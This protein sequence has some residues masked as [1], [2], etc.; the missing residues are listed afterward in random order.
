MGCRGR[1]GRC[2]SM[3]RR[4]SSAGRPAR[5]QGLISIEGLYGQ[6]CHA[7]SPLLT[8]Q[9]CTVPG[10]YLQACLW[11]HTVV[12]VVE[13]CLVSTVASHSERPAPPGTH[14]G[15]EQLASAC[16]LA[17]T[18]ARH[19][20]HRGVKAEHQDRDAQAA[21]GSKAAASAAAHCSGRRH[22]EV[23]CAQHVSCGEVG[24]RRGARAAGRQGAG[25][26]EGQGDAGL[27]LHLQSA[28]RE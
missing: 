18:E 4:R 8:A 17:P 24:S 26:R 15:C 14:C 11:V 12:S 16:Q 23:P 3:D 7:A 5:I 9:T 25:V 13:L 28:E 20:A 10:P 21:A 27:Q 19:S 22:G 6:Q 2:R 1:S